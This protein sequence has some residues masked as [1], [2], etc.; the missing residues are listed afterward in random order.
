MGQTSDAR[1][2]RS[3]TQANNEIVSKKE[4]EEL[5]SLHTALEN[6]GIANLPG[7]EEFAKLP[8]KKIEA[9]A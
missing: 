4:A 8:I 2:H 6:A 3:A 5:N 7:K 9:L 1:L